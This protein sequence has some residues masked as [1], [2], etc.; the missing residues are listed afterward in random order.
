MKSYQERRAAGEVDVERAAAL[1]DV[2]AQLLYNARQ[3]G[4]AY[5]DQGLA[6]SL[7][8]LE[9]RVRAA[10][11]R[12]EL[13][14]LIEVPVV[15]NECCCRDVTWCRQPRGSESRDHCPACPEHGVKNG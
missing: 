10:V 11:G 13:P 9:K 5:C 7:Y 6:E 15:V 8:L 2:V 12:P 14:V 3:R 4:K 1:L